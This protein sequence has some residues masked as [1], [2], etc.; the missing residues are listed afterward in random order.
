M[1]EVIFTTIHGSHLYGLNTPFSDVDTFTVTT[2]DSRARQKVTPDRDSVTIGWDAFLRYAFSG[3]HQ[4]VEA[5]FSPYK[6][7]HSH[8]EL[9]HYLDGMRVTGG[10]A[11]AKYRRTIKSF[12][13][14]DDMKKRRHACRL[15]LNMQGLRYEGRFNPVM[16]PDEKLW[17]S[18]LAADF[19][20]DELYEILCEGESVL[21]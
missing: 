11:L 18:N 12:A 19:G 20:R 21:A 13:Y 4:S 2:S 16:T 1:S 9:R 7:W 17:A 14:S 15:W 10:D 6:E 3:S 5:L 8:H